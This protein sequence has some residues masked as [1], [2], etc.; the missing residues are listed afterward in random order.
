[1]LQMRYLN[2]LYGFLKGGC[3]QW[4]GLLDWTSAELRI[5]VLSYFADTAPW[6]AYPGVSRGQRSHA[7]LISFNFGGYD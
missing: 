1:M 4:T 3:K 5:N 2:Y 7:Y 6:L